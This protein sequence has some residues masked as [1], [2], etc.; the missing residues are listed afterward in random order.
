MSKVIVQRYTTDNPISLMGEEAGICWNADTTDEEKNFKR[1]LNC[2]QSGHLR[3]AEYVQIYL[4]LDGYSARVIRE[5]YTHIGGGPTRLQESTRYVDC[6]NFDY[7]VPYSVSKD[8]STLNSYKDIMSN[9]QED[10]AKLQ[11][12][13]VP[14]EDIAN[15]L[16]LG[17]STKVVVRT[18]LRHLMDMS[19]QRLCTRAY[20]E[21]RNLMH[22]IIEELSY[23]S[24]EWDYLVNDYHIFKRKCEELGYC[25]ESKSCGYIEKLKE[26]NLSE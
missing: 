20:W 7:V 14:K 6:T 23:Y 21:Y 12:A 11:E 17:M 22:D 15:I 1:G 2:L 5:F 18:N 19:K 26:R 16:P 25:P 8:E 24:D 3:V 13:G 10:Y 4:V 9:I